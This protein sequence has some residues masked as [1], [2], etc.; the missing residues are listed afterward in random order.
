MTALLL[1]ACAHAALVPPPPGVGHNVRDHGAVGDGVALDSPAV[2]AAVDACAAG[3]GA[4]TITLQANVTYTLTRV[5]ADDTA[6][7][8][9][10]DITDRFQI[11]DM[12]WLRRDLAVVQA[13]N[14]R[15]RD[16]AQQLRQEKAALEARQ[17]ELNDAAESVTAE[18]DRLR[19][20]SKF[21]WPTAGSVSSVYGLRLH[22]IL[23]YWRMHNG[24]DMT[25]PCGTVVI[26]SY[27]GTVVQAGPN[28]G[29]G[30]QGKK[31][32]RGRDNAAREVIWF[33]KSCVRPDAVQG[34]LF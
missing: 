23:H 4:D 2:Q 28:G 24:V 10:L 1:L 14:N 33:N 13:E 8:G 7:N 18:A 3:N 27:R 30:N 19:N 34:S 29:Y 25:A 20:L 11:E 31:T 21:L 22:P 26:A 32:S 9:D 15:L 16:L 17:S 6:V 5:G 12:D